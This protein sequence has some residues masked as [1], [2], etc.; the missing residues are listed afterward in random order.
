MKLAYTHHKI[1][2]PPEALLTYRALAFLLGFGVMVDQF[3]RSGI[4]CLRFYTVW[5][6]LDH[7]MRMLHSIMMNHHHNMP[8]WIK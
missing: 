5:C 8:V 2:G 6:V 7:A 3:Q 1:T 4:R